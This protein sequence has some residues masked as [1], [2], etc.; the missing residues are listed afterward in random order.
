MVAASRRTALLLIL[1]LSWLAPGVANANSD[2]AA[3]PDAGADH[4]IARAKATARALT[5][6]IATELNHK[7][8]ATVVSQE[9][10]RAMLSLEAERAIM[11]CDDEN[12][13]LSELSDALGA[14]LVVS[15]WLTRIEKRYQLSVSVFDSTSATVAARDTVDGASVDDVLQKLP[16][17]MG[18]VWSASGGA[19]PEEQVR[20]Y[21]RDAKVDAVAFPLRNVDGWS[22]W[23]IGA[24]QVLLTVC[25]G[26]PFVAVPGIALCS[27]PLAIGGLSVLAVWVG[28]H[29]G[30]ERGPLLWPML[31]AYGLALVGF[32]PATAAYVWFAAGRYTATDD[33]FLLSDLG[34]AIGAISVLGG[35]MLALG[36]V[37]IAYALLAEPKSPTDDG[38]GFPGLFSPGH[39]DAAAV[40]EP[41]LP[42][43]QLASNV[44]Y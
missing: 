17:L 21:V 31:I 27:G 7:P 40:V 36:S 10:V 15:A 29:F 5:E 8:D 16:Y 2:A 11:G 22:P 41:P 9:D 18:K 24:L 19:I 32:I 3:D 13:C 42:S 38:S 26:F 43:R 1:A 28:D 12:S 33:A 34:T 14:R 4:D 30:V 37:P 6:A 39:P 25:A 20:V 44:R 23:T 35:G